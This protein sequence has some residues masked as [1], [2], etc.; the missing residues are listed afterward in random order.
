LQGKRPDPRNG[1]AVRAGG[2]RE[3]FSGGG[4]GV[5]LFSLTYTENSHT[6]GNMIFKYLG[7]S[8]SVVLAIT[9]F[10]FFVSS[11]YAGYKYLIG[12]TTQKKS[13]ARSARLI[14]LAAL[15]FLASLFT[16]LFTENGFSWNLLGTFVIIAMLIFGVIQFGNFV[17]SSSTMKESDESAKN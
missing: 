2:G 14:F 7:Y 12:F 4:V 10:F 11:I 5:E 8:L 16:L 13:V 1:R 3:G 6:K 17:N 15:A 9:S